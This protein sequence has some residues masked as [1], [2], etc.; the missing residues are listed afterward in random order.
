ME[1]VLAHATSLQVS[2]EKVRPA[3]CQ[4]DVCVCVCVLLF[5]EVCV[6][7]RL[8]VALL[9]RSHVHILSTLSDSRQKQPSPTW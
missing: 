6:P 3:V 9:S 5:G 8:C 7:L 4:M 1:S 2:F